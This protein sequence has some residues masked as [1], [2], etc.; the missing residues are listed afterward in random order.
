MSEKCPKCGHHPGRDHLKMKVALAIA[1]G[2]NARLQAIIDKLLQKTDDGVYYARYDPREDN[3]P[4]W[5]VW[6]HDESEPWAVSKAHVPQEP[7]ETHLD[8]DIII[9]DA[10]DEALIHGIYS[11]QVAAE[12]AKEKADGH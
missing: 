9:D 2:E 4:L 10:E 7:E 5:V 12:A 11:T 8:F 1:A 3:P 6:R